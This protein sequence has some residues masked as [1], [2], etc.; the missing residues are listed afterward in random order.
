MYTKLSGMHTD[1]AAGRPT[2]QNTRCQNPE[3]HL[4]SEDGGTTLLPT[5]VII[6]RI[7]WRESPE[8]SISKVQDKTVHPCA[9]GNHLQ[10]YLL[11]PCSTVHLEKLTG[12]QLVE[13]FSAF[14]GTQ[15]RFITAFTSA[16]HLSISWASSIQ[17]MPP[18]PTFWRSIIISSHLRLGL[19]SDLF[20]SGFPPK[21]CINLSS[22]QTWYTPRPSHSSRFDHPST[23]GWAH[24][25]H[26]PKTCT[27]NL[28]TEALSFSE[29]PVTNYTQFYTCLSITQKTS[30][31]HDPKPAPPTWRR[32]HS[33]SPKFR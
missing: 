16:R 8:T 30:R 29:T 2:Y 15:R 24:N 22:P 4:E 5:P 18:H 14:Y 3:N 33:V 7:T 25:L 26:N 11:T 20:P 1:L 19:P 32:R 28:T 10:D 27:S 9:V 13:K 17:S 21:P 6:Y 12:S 31:C 23:I